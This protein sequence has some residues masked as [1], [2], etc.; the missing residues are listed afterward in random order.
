MPIGDSELV[1]KAS[2][3]DQDA[4]EE[5]FKKYEGPVYRYLLYLCR[6]PHKAAELY[7][8]TWLRVSNALLN[9]H[10]VTHFKKWLITIATNLFRD[11]L[12][13]KWFQS[14]FLGQEMVEADFNEET[15]P[16]STVVPQLP[17][18][19]L[20]YDLNEAI[21]EGLK[22]LSTKQKTVFILFHIEGY[23]IFE[24]SETLDIAQGTVKA[25]LFKAVRKMR[26]ELKDFR[27]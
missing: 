14:F 25:T 8:E 15:N 24:I 18:G 27:D 5:L 19:D 16:Y 3:G 6:S 9:Q 10:Q 20:L 26:K 2:S 22:S 21:F 1:Q 11:H 23:K 4:F 13:K 12:R 7:Q 17:S